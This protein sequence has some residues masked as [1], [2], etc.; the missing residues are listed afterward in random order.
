MKINKKLQKTKE[1]GDRNCGKFF[2]HATDAF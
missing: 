1:L 2:A